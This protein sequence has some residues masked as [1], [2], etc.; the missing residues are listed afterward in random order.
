MANLLLVVGAVL[1]IIGIFVVAHGAGV[2]Q[3]QGDLCAQS[4]GV[5]V[6]NYLDGSY[7]CI[8]PKGVGDD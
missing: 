4:E 6:K 1:V 2:M 8:H 5:L 3:K 7:V